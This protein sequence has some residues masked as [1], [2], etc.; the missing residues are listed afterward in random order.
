[1][2][3]FDWF[4]FGAYFTLSMVWQC[5]GAWRRHRRDELP[6]CEDWPKKKVGTAPD[7]RRT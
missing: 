1:M 2:T 7:R 5:V 4:M 6:F 3:K